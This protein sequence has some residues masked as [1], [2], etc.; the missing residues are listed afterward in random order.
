MNSVV[1]YGFKISMDDFGTGYS[2]LRYLK[3]FP[4]DVLKVD[5]SFID[6]IVDSAY[7]RYLVED[8]F[9]VLD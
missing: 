5:K 2:S 7:D 3:D 6:H 1:M 4:I 8:V 9:Q